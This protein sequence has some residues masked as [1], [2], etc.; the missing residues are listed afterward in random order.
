MFSLLSFIYG[1]IAGLSSLI[2]II[3]SLFIIMA[4]AMP[5]DDKPKGWWKKN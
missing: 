2:I 1:F 4:W 5:S 3:L